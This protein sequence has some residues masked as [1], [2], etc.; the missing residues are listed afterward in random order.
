MN[1]SK[2]AGARGIGPENK[3]NGR[4]N[5]AFSTSDSNSDPAKIQ[6]FYFDVRDPDGIGFTR[7]YLVGTP[8][9]IASTGFNMELLTEVT[10]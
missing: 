10:L 9:R 5:R 8:E 6:Y 1:Q 2:K 3:F 7:F 4:L